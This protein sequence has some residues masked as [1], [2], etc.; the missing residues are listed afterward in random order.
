MKHII[1]PIFASEF[2]YIFGRIQESVN[3]GSSYIYLIKRKNFYNMILD[4]FL[5]E[6]FIRGYREFGELLVVYFG[7][8]SPG[9]QS[10]APRP[11]T[12]IKAV[13]WLRRRPSL[14]VRDIQ[15]WQKRAGTA[16]MILNTDKG[17]LS[18][19]EAIRQHTGGYPI[20]KI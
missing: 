10:T 11:L 1:S 2:K 12:S 20:F 8:G 4:L 18:A 16:L 7:A 14:R 5:K 13:R 15:R 6:G 9:D 3:S 19:N 17:I